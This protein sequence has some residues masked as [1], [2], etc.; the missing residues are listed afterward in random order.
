MR[1]ARS[2][3][4]LAVSIF[5]LGACSSGRGPASPRE[6]EAN[7]ATSIQ[8][9]YSLYDLMGVER[10]S[11]LYK[12]EPSSSL[13]DAFPAL[14]ANDGKPRW[15]V[16]QRYAYGGALLVA[17]ATAERS[18]ALTRYTAECA[19]DDGVCRWATLT[20]RTEGPTAGVLEVMRST[21][22]PTRTFLLFAVGP[23]DQKERLK[24]DMEK[25]L[26][27]TSGF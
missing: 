6:I 21:K 2:L 1:I 16:V 7:Q 19:V 14:A 26:E 4:V 25:V 5:A 18:A 22:D 23:A 20:G 24:Y 8:Y 10:G 9:A 13:T 17:D 11:H 12:I 27:M 3:L 15:A